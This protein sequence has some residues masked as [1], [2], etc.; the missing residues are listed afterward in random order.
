MGKCA[1][2]NWAEI[3][4]ELLKF[5]P[6]F[7]ILD[8]DEGGLLFRMGKLKKCL[9][10]GIY[11]CFPYVDEISRYTTALVTLDSRNQSITSRDKK[12]IILSWSV[13]YLVH[14]PVKA[15]L[16]IDGLDEQLTACVSYRIVEYVSKHEY[17]KV[18]GHLLPNHVMHKDF[19]EELRTDL[20]ISLKGFYLQDLGLHKIFRII[21]SIDKDSE[22]TYI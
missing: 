22:R 9:G 21:K 18:K 7:E 17:E 16:S 10:P 8:P 2:M 20:G 15:F 14:D 6:R 1:K 11:F 19:I 12:D 3:L 13:T 5:F 4:K